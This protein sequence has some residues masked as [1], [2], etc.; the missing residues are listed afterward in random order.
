MCVF[1]QVLLPEWINSSNRIAFCPS[2]QPSIHSSIHL[3]MHSALNSQTDIMWTSHVPKYCNGERSKNWLARE[4]KVRFGASTPKKPKN[5]SISA[6]MHLPD[7]KPSLAM[8][9]PWFSHQ[10]RDME[11]KHSSLSSLP[12]GTPNS[13]IKLSWHGVVRVRLHTHAKYQDAVRYLH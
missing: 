2:I 10:H 13:C 5:I 6:E 9:F 12:P 4:V 3:S 1:F 8:I 7:S 11:S